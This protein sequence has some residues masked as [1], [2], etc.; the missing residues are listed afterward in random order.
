MAEAAMIDTFGL[1]PGQFRARIVRPTLR[2]IGL[3]SDSAEALV[4]GTAIHES[5]LRYLAQSGG[6]ALGLYQIEPATHRDIWEN[7]L[8]YRPPL[9]RL[10]QSLAATRTDGELIRNLA[11]ATAMCRVRYARAPGALPEA[12]DIDGLAAYWKQNYNTPLGKG[13]AADWARHFRET[14][15]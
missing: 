8:A 12:D 5:G 6:P 10:V 15:A 9:A 3:W 11:Y 13:T 7:Y 2:A 1:N 4:L 14:L